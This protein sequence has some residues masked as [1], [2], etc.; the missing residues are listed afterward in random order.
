MKIE[1]MELH[2]YCSQIEEIERRTFTFEDLQKWAK[3]K[4][5]Q[6][7]A[8]LPEMNGNE[9]ILSCFITTFLKEN[10]DLL[11]DEELNKVIR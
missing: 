10:F 4:C 6:I 2:A 3:E 8:L 1:K 11:E 5:K 7:Y 9:Q